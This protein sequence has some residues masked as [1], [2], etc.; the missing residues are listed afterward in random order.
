MVN[1]T[2]FLLMV[3]AVTALLIAGNVAHAASDSFEGGGVLQQGLDALQQKLSRSSDQASQPR[4]KVVDHKPSAVGFTPRFAGVPIE[5]ADGVSIDRGSLLKSQLS[6]AASSRRGENRAMQLA[7]THDL[8]LV[9]V[10]LSAI[11]GF[12]DH[13]HQEYGQSSTFGVGGGFKFDSLEGLRFDAFYSRRDESLGLA[14]DS[15]TAGMGYDFGAVDTRLSV[16]NVSQYD[17][18][19]IAADE[20]KVWSVGGQMEL[21]SR[22]IVGGDLAYSTSLDGTDDTSGVVN[23]RFNF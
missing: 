17:A 6:G 7:Q 5:L 20:K 3:P 4:L 10:D 21:S 18:N 13:G 14:R 2:K 11:A 9:K 19:G 15:V 22:F 23:F 16:T 8:G 1:E 12:S